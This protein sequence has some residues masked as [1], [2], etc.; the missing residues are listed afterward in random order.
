MKNFQLPPFKKGEPLLDQLSADRL[1]AILD[2]IDRVTP[3][4]GRNTQIV[5]TPGGKIIHSKAEAGSGAPSA[6]P[7]QVID[8]SNPDDGFQGLVVAG[9]V[10]GEFPDGM[11][12]DTDYILSLEEEAWQEILLIVT[13]DPDTLEI[14]SRTLDVSDDPDDSS[15]G[16]LIVAIADIYITYDGAGKPVVTI[17]QKIV[18]DLDF[19]LI[20]GALNGAPALY[21]VQ[22]VGKPI[23]LTPREEDE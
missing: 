9:K 5:S 12:L 18:G 17:D 23:D 14:T 7:F 3:I 11:S 22:V 13:Y 16:T 6:L 10:N 20:Y 4:R 21:A 15:D 1:N 2:A 19:S 8:E